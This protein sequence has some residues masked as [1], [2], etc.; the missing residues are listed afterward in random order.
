MIQTTK[1]SVG[2]VEMMGIAQKNLHFY[3]KTW[4][5]QDRLQQKADMRNELINIGS[6]LSK[7]QNVIR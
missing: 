2:N 3:M 4:N 1:R 5:K 6:C 7:D